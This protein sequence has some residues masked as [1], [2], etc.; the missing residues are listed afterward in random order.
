MYL[1]PGPLPEVE[2]FAAEA[3]SWA[4]LGTSGR[5]SSQ[6]AEWGRLQGASWATGPAAAAVESRR[7]RSTA[8]SCPERD[9]ID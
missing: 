1:C 9:S 6:P 4:P 2:T 3:S 7:M 5:G 8:R